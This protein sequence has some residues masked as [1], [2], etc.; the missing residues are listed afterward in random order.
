MGVARVVVL[1][2]GPEA[3]AIVA[4]L[5][6]DG[7]D[8]WSDPPLTPQAVPQ[9]EPPPAAGAILLTSAN[10]AR[11]GAALFPSGP[12]R[13]PVWA[14]GDA[15]ADAA[16]AAGFVDTRSAGGDAAA[17]AA[18]V[19][20]DPPDGVALHLAGEAVAGDLAGGLAAAGIRYERRVV[21]R[22]KRMAGLASQTAAALS[23]DPAS[24]ALLF[25]SAN[26]VAAF[27][28]CAP[29][30]ARAAPAICI[31]PAVAAAAKAA[32]WTAAQSAQTPDRDAMRAVLSRVA[33]LR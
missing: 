14:V 16:R 17:L 11:F 10:G 5:R 23:D 28:A 32:G 22:M 24:V 18:A 26:G 1:R 19:A 2:G 21:Y 29:R 6:A 15:T 8:A 4:A 9:A 3:D 27:A 31:S 20:A 30:A 7:F 33:A 13:M 25:F 12:P